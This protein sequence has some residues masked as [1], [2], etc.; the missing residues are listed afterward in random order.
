MSA[1][2]YVLA[3]DE[4]STGVRAMLLDRAGRAAG[5]GYREIGASYPRPGRVEQ[6]AEEIWRKTLQ[7]VGEALGAAGARAGAVAAIGIT[8][9]RS[10]AVAWN[11]RTGRALHA[12]LSWQD[13][14]AVE[15]GK[16]LLA[17]G[18]FVTPLAAALKLEWMVRN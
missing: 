3:I 17:E 1:D 6:D 16:E 12:A 9:Q 18:Y 10:T 8:G 4:G 14:R 11:R 5:Q 7:V 15:R 13:L 2:R